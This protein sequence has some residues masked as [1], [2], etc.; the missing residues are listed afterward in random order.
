MNASANPDN[1]EWVGIHGFVAVHEAVHQSQRTV[2]AFY[3]A[4]G[5]AG[6]TFWTIPVGGVVA[7]AAV[8]ERKRTAVADT[9]AAVSGVVAYNDLCQYQRPV[10]HDGPAAFCGVAGYTMAQSYIL[11]VNNTIRLDEEDTFGCLA[12]LLMGLDDRT[13]G[14]QTSD[15]DGRVQ[16][17]T[18]LCV[19][20]IQDFKYGSVV[21][22]R[23]IQRCLNRGIVTTRGT[24][25]IGRW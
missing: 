11:N 21:E 1:S 2:L 8:D 14:A 9:A 12:G 16:N 4:P 5:A 13:L 24:D 17:D 20:G 25:C 23:I 3:T 19:G 22:I 7:D 15:G 18:G 10:V 6:I